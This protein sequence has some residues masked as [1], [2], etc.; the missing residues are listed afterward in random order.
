MSMSAGTV[1]C[2]ARI[3][4]TALCCCLV[5]AWEI[6]F[7]AAEEKCDL[8]KGPCKKKAGDIEISLDISP[9]PV[10]A[11]E[12]LLFSVSVKGGHTGETLFLDLAMP[13]MYMGNNRVFL[14][15][16]GDGK[17]YGKGIIPRCPT[18]KPL[19]S[20]TIELS[21]KTKVEFPFDVLY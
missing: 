15:K 13:G 8:L 17:Y 4:I 6:G 19:W 20:A 18:G 14:K 5:L 10:K 11:M 21:G 7:S 2:G 1:L 12:R 16:A 9:K 3:A